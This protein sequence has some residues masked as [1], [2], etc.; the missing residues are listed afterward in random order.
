MT[1]KCRNDMGVEF[2]QTY[3]GIFVAM[4]GKKPAN[5]DVSLMYWMSTPA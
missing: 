4:T 1:D 2:I 5:G 3:K